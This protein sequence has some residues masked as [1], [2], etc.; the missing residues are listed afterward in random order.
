[1]AKG[2]RLGNMVVRTQAIEERMNRMLDKKA[3]VGY[4]NRPR[5]AT[6]KAS[7]LV[8]LPNGVAKRVPA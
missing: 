3:A 8:I 7:H 1:M 6:N 2:V 5:P 4:Y